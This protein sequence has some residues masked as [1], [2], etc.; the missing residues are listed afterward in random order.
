MDPKATDSSL[1]KTLPDIDPAGFYH[2]TT[3][4]SAQ[5]SLLATQQQQ[6]KHLTSLTEELVRYM[7]ALRLPTPTKNP[8]LSASAATSILPA[9][10]WHFRKKIMDHLR[11][12]RYF[13]FNTSCLSV[14][15]RSYIPW[16]IAALPLS[17]NR[18][19]N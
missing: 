8:P 4:V 18:T 17:V 2:F 14:S 9:P 1:Q 5:A 7:P 3:E 15:S 11:N 10:V 13:C 12:V 6:L 19:S 16:T